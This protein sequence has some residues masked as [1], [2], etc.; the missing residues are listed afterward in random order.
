MLY[1]DRNQIK[2]IPPEIT[3]LINTQ[4]LKL[5]VDNQTETP[6][7][8]SQTYQIHLLYTII[9]I[10]IIIYTTYQMYQCI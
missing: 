5:H 7:E 9:K 6:Y 10:I 2:E 8:I 3:Q 1:L 4:N